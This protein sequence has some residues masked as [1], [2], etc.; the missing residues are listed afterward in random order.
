VI[1]DLDV[2]FMK[3]RRKRV[4]DRD[5]WISENIESVV[6]ALLSKN[7]KVINFISR[8]YVDYYNNKKVH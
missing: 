7:T 5:V 6:M 2:D 1:P 8:Y 3:E 4:S